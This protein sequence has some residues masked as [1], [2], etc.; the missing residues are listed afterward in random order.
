LRRAGETEPARLI[1]LLA[2]RHFATDISLE[3]MFPFIAGTVDQCGRDNL[4]FGALDRSQIEEHFSF[5]A[6]C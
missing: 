2:Y 6:V 5:P 3:K 1:N 4:T